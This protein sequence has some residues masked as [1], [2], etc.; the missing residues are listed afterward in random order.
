[1]DGILNINKPWGRTSYSIVAQVKRLSGERRVG[2]AG[3]LDPAAT[4]VLPVCL[5]RSTR[6][7]EYLMDTAKTYMA[8]VELGVTT[9]TGDV[10]GKII[11]QGDPAG[12]S[13]GQL[14]SALASFRGLIQQVPPMYSAV[15]HNGRRLYELARAGTEVERQPRLARIYRLELVDYKPPVVTLEVECSKGTYIRTLAADLGQV[16]GCGA[17]LKDLTRTRCGF[18]NVKEAVSLTQLEAAFRYGYWQHYVYPADVVLSQWAAVVVSTDAE[19]AIRNGRS[20]SLGEANHL[21]LSFAENRCRAYNLD[22]CFLAVLHF[23]A[24]SGQWHPE[25]VFL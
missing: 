6:V 16:L 1:M 24:E 25:K 8:S 15:K 11:C 22:G 3:T 4:G 19:Q 23:D 17:H 2:H 10:Q 9:D 5:G 12:I 18:F 7:T 14:E 21:P 20:L 13:Y